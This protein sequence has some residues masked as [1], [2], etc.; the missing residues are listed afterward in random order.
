M[1]AGWVYVLVN[2][3]M[4]GL[5]KVGKTTRAPSDR[6]NELSGV[7]GVATPFIVAFEQYFSNCDAAEDYV[8][9]ELEQRGLRQ[10]GNREFFRASPNEV[11]RIV[12][13]AP[14]SCEQPHAPNANDVAEDMDLLSADHPNDD[15]TLRPSKPWDDLLRE[16]DQ[17]FYGFGDVIRDF[18][19]AQRL[20]RDAARLGSSLAYQSLGDIYFHGHGV[21]ADNQKALQFYKEGMKKG[22]YYCYAYMA[23]VFNDAD[24][25]SNATKAWKHFFSIRRE[26]MSDEVEQRYT[27]ASACQDYLQFCQRHNVTIE[28]LEDMRP[29]ADD[30]IAYIERAFAVNEERY[31]QAGISDVIKRNDA[32]VI[33]WIRSNLMPTAVSRS[34]TDQPNDKWWSKLWRG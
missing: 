16:A 4:P 10:A 25:V 20:Y 6:A 11:V 22:N 30:T 5:V 12:L 27:F 17:H 24:E 7:T 23:E 32:E 14:G 29:A 26:G 31:R 18:D 9:A 2:S 3:S 15:L 1:A 21:T 19:E 33:G 8:H 28:F 34:N 13:L